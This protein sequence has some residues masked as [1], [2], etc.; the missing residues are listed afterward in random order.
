MM[1]ARKKV[2]GIKP[3][4]REASSDNEDEEEAGLRTMTAKKMT[5]ELHCPQLERI[6]VEQSHRQFWL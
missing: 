3:A 1:K 5:V 2:P 4:Y 6:V